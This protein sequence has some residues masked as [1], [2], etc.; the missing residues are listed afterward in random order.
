MSA[1]LWPA[2]CAELV[3]AGWINAEGEALSRAAWRDEA[4][5]RVADLGADWFLRLAATCWA[6]RR[7]ARGPM[8]LRFD[9]WPGC[10]AFAFPEVDARLWPTEL[11]QWLETMQRLWPRVQQGECLPLQGGAVRLQVHW[12]DGPAITA[13]QARGVQA[14]N[15][16]WPT[17]D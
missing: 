11:G 1:P 7:D 15:T 4:H 2:A 9:A 10:E 5:W 14:A 3:R 8:A 12:G 17:R 6:W 16:V 13:A